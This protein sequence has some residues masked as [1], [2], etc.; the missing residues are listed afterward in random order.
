M[1]IQCEAVLVTEAQLAEIIHETR[2]TVFQSIRRHLPADL[3]HAVED[4]V[5]ETYLRFYLHFQHRSLPEG[6]GRQR[7]LYV[8]ARNESRK[9]ARSAR[10]RTRLILAAA[11]TAQ[12]ELSSE[13]ERRDDPLDGNAENLRSRLEVQTAVLPPHFR[14]PMQLRLQGLSLKD[15]ARRLSLAAG[16]VKSRLARGRE[17]LA[18]EQANTG[19]K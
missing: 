19:R 14:Q 3:G 2:A 11:Q 5:Q 8:A 17:L 9:A 16:T 7:W 15:I 4:V 18:R 10:R 12:S 6:D 13:L 1:K